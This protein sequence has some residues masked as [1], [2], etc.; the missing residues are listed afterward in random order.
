MLVCSDFVYSLS[1]CHFVFKYVWECAY[2]WCCMVYIYW[3]FT[4]FVCD[5]YFFILE[6][7]VDEDGVISCDDLMSIFEGA[8]RKEIM[9]IIDE[10][11]MDQDGLIKLSLRKYFFLSSFYPKLESK[12]ECMFYV[13][14]QLIINSFEEFRR[15]MHF[16]PAYKKYLWIKMACK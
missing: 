1:F 5:Y 16:K 3:W 9:S 8:S 11:D 7:D 10:V 14:T 12:F 15:A 4:A 13:C 2:V 6:L